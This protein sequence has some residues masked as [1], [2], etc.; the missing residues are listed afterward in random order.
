MAANCLRPI[1]CIDSLGMS[2]FC[3]IN[4][5][6]LLLLSLLLSLVLLCAQGVKLHVHNLDQGHDN[7]HSHAIDEVGDHDHLSKAHFTYDASHDGYHDDV[8]SEIDISPDGLLKSVNSHVFMIA[9]FAFFFT[10]ITFI[11][12]RQL[13]QRCRE[14][15]LILHR[16]Y[17][18]SPPLR[19]PPQY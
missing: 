15:K 11:S 4:R 3:Q 10:L 9:L 19:A 5:R 18:L 8:V 13:I 17:V 2:F 14:S 7:H 1:N 12:S 16:Q 6:T